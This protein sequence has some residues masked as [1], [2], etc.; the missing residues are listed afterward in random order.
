MATEGMTCGR[1]HLPPPSPSP[2]LSQSPLFASPP[3]FF[4]RGPAAIGLPICLPF[5]CTPSFLLSHLL[6]VFSLSVSLS[7]VYLFLFLRAN[8][9]RSSAV[10]R[11]RHTPSAWPQRGPMRLILATLPPR[12]HHSRRWQTASPSMGDNQ[13]FLASSSQWYPLF[14]MKVLESSAYISV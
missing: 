11:W 1:S 6:L 4:W 3:H 8:S 2:S 14:T 10:C 5:S 13:F 12:R 7:W 9:D